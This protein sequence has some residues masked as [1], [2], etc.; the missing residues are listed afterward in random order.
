M[1]DSGAT[2]NFM[3]LTYFNKLK[4]KSIRRQIPV[5]VRV[6]DGREIAGGQISKQTPT[7]QLHIADIPVHDVVFDVIDIP[8]FDVILGLPWL[9]YNNP[10]I[11]WST[12]EL[13]NP[14]PKKHVQLSETNDG[15]FSEATETLFSIQLLPTDSTNTDTANYPSK[16]LPTKYTEYADVFE[17]K[18]ADL[19]PEHRPFDIGIDLKPGEKAPW[20]PIYSLSEPELKELRKYLDENL[21]KQFIRPSKSPAGAPILFVKKKD[22]SLRLC[23]DYRGLNKVT[24]KNRYPL[25]LMNDLLQQLKSAKVFSR[26]DLR[27]AYNLVRVRE[28]DEWK[29]AFRCRYG[30][31]EYLVM[32]FGLSN[33]PATF[34]HLMHDIFR[35]MLDY[36]VI[37]Y[38]DDIL[39]F[40]KNQ[41][42]HD[43]NVMEV[44]ARLRKHH[45]YA[46]LEKCEFDQTSIE[47]LGYVIS[48][49]GIKMD[50]KK[51]E[52]ILSWPE[53]ENVS[54]IQ[55]FLGFCNFYRS[56]IADFTRIALP[57]TALLKKD[58][59]FI[60][61]ATTSKAFATLKRMFCSAPLLAHADPHKPFL[62]ETDASDYAIAGVLSQSQDDGTL[63]PVGFFSRKL[64]PAEINYEIHDKELLA[65]IACFKEW[66][67]LLMGAQ[68]TISVVTDHKNLVYF[69]DAKHM[70]RRQARWSMFL[71]DFD[72]RIVYRA[73]KYGA[74]PD[75]LTRRSD[76]VPKPGDLTIVQ[77]VKSIIPLTNFDSSMISSLGADFSEP[78]LINAKSLIE[79]IKEAQKTDTFVTEP[80]EDTNKN[81]KWF[82]GLALFHDRIYVPVSKRLQVLQ[83]CHDSKLAG[84]T[85]NSKTFFNVSKSFWFPN[86][87]RY[88]TDFVASCET[89]AR[90]KPS[91]QLPAG[92][93]NP[94][95]IPQRPWWS[96]SWDFITGLPESNGFNSILVVVCRLTKMSHYI[97][98]RDTVT[99]Y[100]LADIF[101]NEVFRLHGVPHEIVSDRGPVFVSQFWREVT[102]LL[103][104]ELGLS[105]AFH[106]QTDGQTERV[107]QILEQYLRC[108]VDYQQTNW[109]SLLP[110]AE[111]S[112]NSS[113]HSSTKSSPFLLNYGY[114]PYFDTSL[115]LVPSQLSTA[116]ERVNSIRERIDFA[117]NE[118]DLA[119]RTQKLFA[120]RKRRE[121]SF[122]VGDMVYLNR[123]NIKTSRPSQKLDFKKLGPF[124]IIAKIG[125]AAYKLQLPVSMGIHNVFHISLLQP[126]I[127]NKFP[128]RTIP[129]PPPIA[130]SDHMEFEV[131][132]ILDSK[133]T[134]SGIRYLVSWVGYGPQDNTWEPIENLGNALDSLNDYH[135]RYP[136]KPR[137]RYLSARSA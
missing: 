40:S 117:K 13:S 10:V 137:P 12:M 106:P 119:Q 96:I 67:H 88:I 16:D 53:P 103:G 89:C 35:D 72:Y 110:I 73:G 109:S 48:V 104:V 79:E 14:K 46:K 111:F 75:L 6:V 20:G 105:T 132:E 18:N 97:A 61:D 114:E 51:V 42:E 74:K 82:N 58:T 87:R 45:L 47:F 70:N 22:G 102:R 30:H 24:I 17:K 90:V 91:R 116:N 118:L 34:Q 123:K 1:V 56:F 130:V 124:K 76:L 21:E 28:G 59:E 120:D 60:W 122:N 52:T 134:R 100:Q 98:C 2:G 83:L 57:I 131:S 99:S 81:L 33:A 71:T 55:S 113:T 101:I 78:L 95:P 19:L 125:N 121:L 37:I 69:A 135:T 27:G 63:H 115:E 136:N 85:G 54:D 44:L 77:Q 11:N 9:Q 38:L 84:H 112:Y 8:Q 80:D 93:L 129:L 7:L 26:I 5:T 64:T 41:I 108:F 66:R 62:L 32:P 15:Q 4:I 94:L 128:G 133:K 49:D 36:C 127:P 23:V 50:P 25:P 68:H 3:S 29:T 92:L 126:V 31:F 39:I 43:R 65:I 107:N 86:M